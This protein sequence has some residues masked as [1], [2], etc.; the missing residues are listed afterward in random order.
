MLTNK[1]TEKQS[2]KELVPVAELR[3]GGVK[4]STGEGDPR[5][6]PLNSLRST[7]TH[8]LQGC[9]QVTFQ[10]IKKIIAQNSK[11]IRLEAS[12]QTMSFCYT[13]I[14]CSLLLS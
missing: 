6:L 9:L 4:I 10:L 7:A 2:L 14:L 3:N 5:A 11:V 1:T 13:I 8:E 12:E